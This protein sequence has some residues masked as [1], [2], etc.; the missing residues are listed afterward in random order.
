MVRPGVTDSQDDSTFAESGQKRVPC[1]Y[2]LLAG[3]SAEFHT[4]LEAM[5]KAE[6]RG[7]TP[8]Q[9][10]AKIGCVARARQQDRMQP[11]PPGQERSLLGND[12]G[13]TAGQPVTFPR[14]VRYV[15]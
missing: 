1:G 8:E 14:V 7:L 13:P 9:K 4:G 10:H 12:I 11:T 3:P 15:L 2:A 5:L 6:G